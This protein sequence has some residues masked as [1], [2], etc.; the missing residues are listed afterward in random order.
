MRLLTVRNFNPPI[1]AEGRGDVTESTVYVLQCDDC[2][3]EKEFDQEYQREEHKKRNGWTT[4]TDKEGLE[5][6]RCG[7][8][9]EEQNEK[10][11]EL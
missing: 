5:S 2:Q 1:G 10:P 11:S 3:A 6:D 8:C 4:Y 9:T 7:E